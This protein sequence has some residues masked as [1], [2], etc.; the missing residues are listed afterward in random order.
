M[1]N[2][3]V[4]FPIHCEEVKPICAKYRRE[5]HISKSNYSYTVKSIVNKKTFLS[6]WWRQRSWTTLGLKKKL[7]IASKHLKQYKKILKERKSRRAKQRNNEWSLGFEALVTERPI[8][9]VSCS[10]RASYMRRKKDR[11]K[12]RMKPK[13]AGV[14]LP[15]G[16]WWGGEG[17]GGEA[18]ERTFQ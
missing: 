5:E 16:W 15:R 12:I 9:E 18:D 6:K 8:L 2:I 3:I 17:H 10:N 1:L 11:H 14:Q 13:P 4:L 7:K